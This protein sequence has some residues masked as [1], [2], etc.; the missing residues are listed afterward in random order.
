MPSANRDP[1]V[2]GRVGIQAD[3]VV[4][5]ADV[6]ELGQDVLSARIGFGAQWGISLPPLGPWA[7]HEGC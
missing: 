1:L 4:A 7:E 3:L 6:V 5:P 2:V